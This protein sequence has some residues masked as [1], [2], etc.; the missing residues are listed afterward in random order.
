MNSMRCIAAFALLPVL[1]AA[2][3]AQSVTGTVVDT[4]GDA[5][6]GAEVTLES[7]R[8][9]DRTVTD[10]RGAFSFSSVNGKLRVTAPGFEPVTKQIDRAPAGPLAITLQPSAVVGNVN[11]SVTGDDT[12]QT[13]TAASIAVINIDSLGVTAARSLD[14]TLRQIAGFQLFRRSGSRTTNPTAQGGNLRG[15]SG[16]G[17]SRASVLSDGLSINDAFGGWTYWS[18]V[19]VIAVEQVEVLRGGASAVYGSGALSGAVNIV[20]L[21]LGDEKVKFRFETSLASQ[22]SADASGVLLASRGKWQADLV[23]DIFKTAGYIP[24]ESVS[25]GTADTRAASRHSNVIVKL[26]RR[27]AEKNRVFIRGNLFGERRDNGTSLTNNRTYYRQVAA[28]ADLDGLSL[29][30]FGERQVYDQTFSAVSADRNS[31]TLTR[32]QRVPSSA[33]G[34][35]V[36]WR[37]T[38]ARHG[39]ALGGEILNVRGRSDEVGFSAGQPT[40]V[41]SAGGEARDLAM[42][43]HDS[44][45]FAPRFVLNLS[46]RF[47]QRRNSDGI[48]TTRTLASGAVV[49][50]RF[51]KRTDSA[52]SPRVGVVYEVTRDVSIYGAYSRS[53]RAP[54]LNELYRGFRV[55]NIITNANAFLTPERADTFEAGGSAAFFSRKL[56]TRAIVYQARVY[57]PVVSVTLSTTPT[58]IT[59]QRRNVGSTTSRGFEFDLESSPAKG[60]KVNASY[61][62]VDAKISDFG[63]S[64]DLVGARLPQVARHNFT[65]QAVYRY[66]TRWT[67]STQLRGTSSQFEDDRNTLRLRSFLTTDAR[68]SYQFPYFVEGF[69]SAENLFDSRYDIGLTPVRTVAAPRFVRVGLRV[70]FGKR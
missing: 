28:G 8:V 2:L 24:V 23:G 69:V 70:E 53:F 51:T 15:V 10:E 52:L 36:S 26:G 17:A 27:F 18:R 63:A 44:W 58:L 56:I 45:A 60:L 65:T 22:R 33:Y 11:V 21:K 6:V 1:V 50:A 47:D 32:I 43:V 41:A 12:L 54:S 49:E 55:G 48:A 66:R 46:A 37:E 29:R 5:V 61:L 31:E 7:G 64:P 13:A 34:A 38:F 4:R 62:L 57:D 9:L 25:R 40:S 67:L 68:F 30:A 16:S 3:G 14:D 59:R 19:P 42:F 35:S 20:R 39:T